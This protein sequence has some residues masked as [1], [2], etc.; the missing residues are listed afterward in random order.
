MGKKMKTGKMFGICML[1]F[2][3]IGPLVVY[4]GTEEFD[5]AMNP[6]VEQYLKIHDALAEDNTEGVKKA[7][8]QIVTLSDKVDPDTVTGEHKDHYRDLP[9]KIKE[10]AQKLVPGKDLG[11]AREAFKELSRPMAMWATMSKPKGVYVVYCSM[12]RAS[13]LQKDKAIRNPY[14]GSQMLGC[15][16]IVGGEDHDKGPHGQH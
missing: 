2:A 5:K 16:E 4:G 8:E 9:V 13:W 3:L 11:A 1:L 7:A 15:G 10:A 6:L 14:H 12:Q